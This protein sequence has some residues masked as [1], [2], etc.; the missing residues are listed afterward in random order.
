MMNET[1]VANHIQ[2]YTLNNVYGKHTH[3][4]KNWMEK[5]ALVKDGK[6]R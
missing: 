6:Q 4:C 3:L 1:I 2:K 5:D